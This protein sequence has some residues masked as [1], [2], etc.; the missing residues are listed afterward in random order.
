MRH[1]TETL[2]IV[3]HQ[4]AGRSLAASRTLLVGLL[5]I[6]CW[7]A[8]LAPAWAQSP[9]GWW[10]LDETSGTTALDS[11]GTSPA[12]PG[13]NSNA[14]VNQPGQV[15]TAYSFNGTSAYVAIPNNAPLQ[16]NSGTV[17]AWIKTSSPG[18]NYRGIVVKQSAYGLFL[19]N[20]QFGL[21]SWGGTPAFRNT[22]L[23]LATLGGTGL[24][25]HVAATF[26]SG[27]TNGTILYVDGS[28]V[29]TTTMTV[30]NQTVGVAIGNGVPSTSQSQYFNGV[31]DEVKVF[32]AVLAPSVVCTEAGKTWNG[33][34]CGSGDTTPPTISAVTAGSLTNSGATITW[35]TNEAADT[36][37]EY[38]TT[39]SYGSSTPLVTTLV[40]SHSQ[41]L[42]GLAASTL[43]HYRVRS[44]DAA[45][46]LATSADAMFTTS[47]A[48]T[49]TVTVSKAGGAASIGTVTSNVGGINCG[50]TCTSSGLASGTSVTLTASAT[51]TSYAFSGACT[52]SSSTCM[53][54]LGSANA[55]VT[56]TFTDTQA[57]G[58]PGTP[59]FSGVTS[60]GLTVSW[61]AAA[62][63]V[64]VTGYRLERCLTASC[65]YAQIATPTTT[66]Y[67]D[68]GLTASTSYTYR[69]RAV[70]AAGNLSAY[71]GTGTTLTSGSGTQAWQP[72]GTADIAYT[73]GNVGIGTTSPSSRLH[74]LDN[75]NNGTALKIVQ[76][77]ATASNGLTIQTQ[78]T[79]A[80]DAALYVTPGGGTIPGLIVRNSGNVGIGTTGPARSLHV[81][82]TT[83]NLLK[84]ENNGTG[85]AVMEIQS[86][87]NAQTAVN[88]LDSAGSAQG[89]IAYYQGTA[90]NYMRF[91][92]LGT[93]RMRIDSSGNVGI[94]GAP[95]TI[96]TTKLQVTGDANFTGTV[97]G[98]NI[99]ANYQDVAEWVPSPAPLASGTVV[100]LDM[101]HNNQVIASTHAYDTKVAGVIS[102][103]PG[104][105][106][107]VAGENKVKVATTGR[108]RVKVDASK[109]AI[110]VGD[111]LVTSDKPGV[112]MV[113][114]P[115]D[116]NGVSMHRPGTIVGKALEPLAE[117]EGEILVLLSLQ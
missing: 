29:L 16:L 43:Y 60:S 52:S 36:Q 10:K 98:G 81:Y 66:S 48:A 100:I 70:D 13:T 19:Y 25:H 5:G 94:G 47:A 22:G 50:A 96:A 95:S 68:S 115:V 79:S 34:S 106:L 113:S 3:R 76:T 15:G 71:S 89:Q 92:T 27:V 9:I 31:I 84:I 80:G 30:S 41:T 23:N 99:V 78:T 104:L 42:S 58:L 101:E 55:S 32:S 18:T 116:V 73:T 21:Y 8:T 11:S 12:S 45:G 108:V 59:T 74:V 56:V 17:E 90:N 75:T 86:D 2:T 24:W 107:G 63:N 54:I 65:T 61:P 102:E 51:G 44:K 20:S 97:T 112:A 64:G 38:G 33:S 88:F 111:L 4:R 72:S 82:G 77:N 109:S 6:L 117:G 83:G 1:Q 39:T 7:S 93:E 87:N 14:T 69:V 57:P 35:T 85:N 91:T 49:Y 103:M 53:W 40:T 37:V 46:N 26:Q 67:T 114:Q 28:A 105:L 62:D 110:K